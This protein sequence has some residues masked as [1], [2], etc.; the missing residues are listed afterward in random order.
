MSPKTLTQTCAGWNA[1][2][3][4]P[5]RSRYRAATGG[6]R[7]H[8]LGRTLDARIAAGQQSAVDHMAEVFAA[9]EAYDPQRAK[10]VA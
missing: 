4:D 5:H 7:A 2:A 6:L 1:T 10:P 9:R 3:C 8:E